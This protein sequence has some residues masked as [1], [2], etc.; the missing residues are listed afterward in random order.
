[1]EWGLLLNICGICAAIIA[2]IA[3]R[4]RFKKVARVSAFTALGYTI[5]TII[6]LILEWHAHY[7]DLGS[8]I[9][10]FGFLAALTAISGSGSLMAIRNIKPN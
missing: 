8:D 6:G 5:L 7:W 1:M 10:I 2:P 4:V 9:P 3:V